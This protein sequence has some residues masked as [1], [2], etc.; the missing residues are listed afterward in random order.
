[1]EKEK[2]SM[3]DLKN[4]FD[5]PKWFSDLWI[6]ELLDGNQGQIQDHSYINLIFSLKQAIEETSLLVITNSDGKIAYVSKSFCEAIHY[7]KE[8]LLGIDYSSLQ[9]NSRSQEKRE[10]LN[11]KNLTDTSYRESVY[12][13]KNG[14]PLILG[15]TIH[16][17]LM[18]EEV[19]KFQAILLLHKD[20]TRLKQ[21]EKVI[22]EITAVDNL[23]GLPN[24]DRF[25]RDVSERIS[26]S[27]DHHLFV[28]FFIDL[29]RFKFYNDTLGHFTGDKLIQVIGQSL[30]NLQYENLHVYRYGG[31]EFALLLDK[32]SSKREAHQLAQEILDLFQSPFQVRGNELFITASIGISIFPEMGKTYGE[33]VH[34][35]EMAMQYAKEQGK[36]NIQWFHSSIRTVHDERLLLEKRLRIATERKH[37]ELNYQPQI[38]LLQQEVI[39]V[40]ALIRWKDKELGVISP[41]LFIP[42]AEETGL[43]VSI[44]DW[45]LEE[46]MIQAKKWNDEGKPLRISVNISPI[47]FQRPDFVSKVKYNLKKTGLPPELLDLEITENDLMYNQEECLRTLER[48]KGLGIRISIDD[49][50]TGYS[51][52]SYLRRFPID[53]LKI[54]QSFIKELLNNAN[55]QA[56][57]TSIIQLAHNMNLRVIAE[58]VET[59]DMVSF[60]C[61]RKCD[62]MQGFLYSKALPPEAVAPFIESTNPKKILSY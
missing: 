33:V 8:D 26:F 62:E 15:V 13:T 49:F 48:L 23:T 21:A 51:S 59:I 17:L 22:K 28:L 43:I 9:T 56:I 25:E 60:L 27:S 12:R 45:V 4:D 35:A 52:L 11:Q 24:R 31:D 55:D 30:I 20:I 10:L 44:G 53:T 34:Q 41:A 42:L 54:D 37:F 6:D 38:D 2:H 16:P 40:E 58:G 46:A 14:N 32:P 57:V 29:D 47:Q 7:T 18:E 1:M 39:G 3:E 36:N 50:G 5:L 61:N 19:G